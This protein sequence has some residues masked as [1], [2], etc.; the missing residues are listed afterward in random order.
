MKR[1]LTRVYFLI[2]I[3]LMINGV[4]VLTVQAKSPA[5]FKG[6]ITVW[7]W[8]AAFSEYMGP[9]F[10]KVYPNIKVNYITV[11][12]PDYM[13]KLQSAIATGSDVPDVL[14]GEIAWRGRLFDMNILENLEKPPYNVKRSDMFAYLTPLLSNSRNEIVGVDQGISPAG[15]AY[16]RDLAKKY[17]GTDDPEKLSAMINKWDSFIAKGKEV[18]QKSGGKVFM[19]P[20]LGDVLYAA[21][22]Q[23]AMEYI[24]GN[25]VNLTKRLKKPLEIALKV[26][27]AGIVAK[28]ELWSPGWNASFAKGD[29]IFFN[30]APW[31]SKWHVSANDRNGSGRWGLMKAP[32]GGFT[33]GGT[34]VGIYKGSKNKAAAWEY[35]KWVYYSKEGGKINFEKFGNLTSLKAFYEGA[36]PINREG[37]YDEFFG[38]QNLARYYVDQISPKVKGQRQTKYETVVDEAFYRLVPLFMKDTSI[39]AK[40][41]LE[42]FISEVKLNAPGAIVK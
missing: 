40:K 25:Q 37:N 35:I 34:S 11:N 15:W 7:D 32:E 38:G 8:D 16:R 10:N 17:L 20:G 29:V 12:H 23:A 28:Y 2:L 1:V 33:F 18:K 5:D 26:R 14:L 41:A 42:K 19:M 6:A 21:K 24:K 22:N 30:M 4:G 31:G 9:K 27:D 36:S 39:N 13:Q 3:L